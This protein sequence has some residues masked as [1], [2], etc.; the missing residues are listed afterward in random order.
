MKALVLLAAVLLSG[1]IQLPAPDCTPGWGLSL[2]QHL[3]DEVA[4]IGTVEAPGPSLGG[5]GYPGHEA[6]ASLKEIR[7]RPLGHLPGGNGPAHLAIYAGDPVE[8]GLRNPNELDRAFLDQVAALLVADGSAM[9]DELLQHPT[10]EFIQYR[11]PVDD[12]DLLPVDVDGKQSGGSA[13]IGF[14]TAKVHGDHTIE[15]VWTG[16]LAVAELATLHVAAD[17]RGNAFIDKWDDRPGVEVHP[18]IMDEFKAA[19]LPE[20]GFAGENPVPSYRCA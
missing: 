6:G 13:G 10:G 3:F 19:G 5:S 17:T 2:D 12:I 4:A 20:P 16:P 18:Q 1:C 7:W 15:L 11:M 9:I 14:W 8:V